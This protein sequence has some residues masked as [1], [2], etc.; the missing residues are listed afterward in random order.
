MF[1][2]PLHICCLF[3]ESATP[4]CVVHAVLARLAAP[5]AGLLFPV[6]NATCLGAENRSVLIGG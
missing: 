2:P 1:W 3:L 4:V 5:T 6:N